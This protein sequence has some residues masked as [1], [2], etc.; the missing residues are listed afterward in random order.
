MLG[1]E[2]RGRW[3]TPAQPEAGTD[4][5]EQGDGL[6]QA[7]DVL[8]LTAGPDAEPLHECHPAENEERDRFAGTESGEEHDRILADDDGHRGGGAARRDPVA[9]ADDETGIVAEAA[10]DEDVL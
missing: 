6:E 10:A 1:D 9:P 5:D 3:I 2:R 8:G 7:G 4:E